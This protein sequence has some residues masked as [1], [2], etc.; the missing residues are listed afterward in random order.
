MLFSKKSAT[1]VGA[2]AG[3]SSS[4][5]GAARSSSGQ[6]VSAKS[7]LSI[8]I[9]Q[10][11]V[12]LLAESVAQLPLDIYERQ[13]DGGRKSATD[14]P[15]Y[16]L[17]KYQP[18]GWQTPFEY[19]EYGQVSAGL[20]GN[21]FSYIERDERG[22]IS[23]LYP[24]DASK[25]AVLKGPDLLP[26]YQI[27]TNDPI[28]SRYVHHVRWFSLDGYVGISPVALHANAIGYT[29]ALSEYSAKSFLNGTA[30]SGVLE[31]PRDAPA[32]KDPKAVDGITDSWQDKFGGSGNTAKV[33]LLQEGMT[34]RPLTMSNVDAELIN[35][36]KLSDSDIS[37]IYKIPL[38]MVGSLEG[39]TYNN[40]EN[41]QIQFV[42]YALMPWLRRHEQAMQRDFLSKKE[43]VS[44][45]IEFNIGGLLRG[46]QQARYAAYAVGRQW[47]WLSI[48][49][50]RRLE[51]LPPVKGGD[52][53]L[54]PLNM[55]DAADPKA[56]R[57]APGA[58]EKA[59]N[60]IE[61]VLF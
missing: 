54:Q 24:L 45:Y 22:A 36:L 21:S 58:D 39:A 8:P 55:V 37:R 32:I 28:P 1:E 48:N 56:S 20:R 43:R 50:I 46:N 16:D 23:A 11:C 52:V 17:L 19:R 9:L 57:P 44:H 51:N 25:V 59:L 61:K 40:V 26:Y 2:L 60:E 38:P 3:W 33:A 4:I 5:L 47:G 10:E 30:L 13:E 34:F 41:L 27:G 53:Y 15:L 18:N 35:A 42:I 12:S 14:H 6:M 31:R 7:A 29:L 49:D